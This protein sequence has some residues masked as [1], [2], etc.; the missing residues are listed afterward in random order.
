MTGGRDLDVDD[1]VGVAVAPL[2]GLV[3]VAVERV[4][5]AKSALRSR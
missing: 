3:L 2:D 5:K 1:R 4:R